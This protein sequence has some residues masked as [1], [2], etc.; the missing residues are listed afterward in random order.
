MG[1]KGGDEGKNRTTSGSEVVDY[2][3]II[4]INLA[5]WRESYNCEQLLF[6]EVVRQGMKTGTTRTSLH[7]LISPI[8]FV[9]DWQR[10]QALLE[11]QEKWSFLDEIFFC[12]NIDGK[13]CV[14]L[15]VYYGKKTFVTF[16]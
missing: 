8:F 12:K 1:G 2:E 10:N 13:G 11:R 16:D 9:A 5:F 4:E 6:S 3:N 15:P 7:G 14:I